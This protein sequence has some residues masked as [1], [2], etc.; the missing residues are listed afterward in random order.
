MSD[1][2][3]QIVDHLTPMVGESTASNMLRHYCARM[4]MTAEAITESHLPEL[5]DA[6]KPM[7]AVWLGSMGAARVAEEIARLGKGAIAR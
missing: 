2:H 1:V 5:A 4:Q 7:L 3:K 6:M